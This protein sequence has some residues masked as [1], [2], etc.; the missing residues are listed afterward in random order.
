MLRDGESC[1]ARPVGHRLIDVN[2]TLAQVL[3]YLF[4]PFCVQYPNGNIRVSTPANY[5]RRTWHDELVYI[6][7]LIEGCRGCHPKLT[8]FHAEAK[9]VT[10]KAREHSMKIVASDEAEET[11]ETTIG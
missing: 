6:E 11:E 8:W 4:V 9:L 7:K 5:L 3:W 2:G 1:P 10:A